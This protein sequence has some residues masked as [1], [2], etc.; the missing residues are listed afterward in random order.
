MKIMKRF[1]VIFFIFMMVLAPLLSPSYAQI[2]NQRKTA[3][4]S[5][6][7][8]LGPLD[9]QL[10]YSLDLDITMPKKIT[11]GT[12][13]EV[14]IFPSNGRLQTTFF[15]EGIS[16]GPF[17]NQINLGQEKDI[18]IEVPVLSVYAKPVILANPKVSG[19][20]NISP[21]SLPFT[22]MTPKSIQIH[23]SNEIGN[24]N[25]INL[26]IPIILFLEVGAS[27]DIP[28]ILT[29][30][31]PVETFELSKFSTISSSISLEKFVNTRLNL[32]VSDSSRSE[33]IKVNPSLSSDKGI[34][35][36]YPVKIY[37]DERFKQTVQS[38]RWSN[39]IWTG[40]GT[41]T[42]KAEFSQTSDKSNSAIIYRDSTD[43]ES[44]SLKQ[45]TS[46]QITPTKSGDLCGAGTVLKDGV[47]VVEEQQRGGGCL[48]ATA[49]YGS[50]LA[51]QVQQL[52]EIRDNTLLETESGSAFM[53]SFNQF[54]YSFSPGIADLERENPVFKEAVKIAI[55]PLITS[56]SIL[57][58]VDID[59]EAEVLGY[60]ISLIL[61]NVGMYFV[62]PA[63]VISKIRKIKKDHA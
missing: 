11:A 48:I 12:I 42:I 43:F 9:I 35:Y 15:L 37:I 30:S 44:Y 25:S 57:N 13:E 34:L 58:Y 22:S 63:I 16:Y 38:S 55:T 1:L 14:R 20:A 53:E 27:I 47:C 50:E 54:Y 61:L 26:Q 51:P 3:S 2:N 19:P 31:Y 5:E 49:T 36:D 60:G 39:E 7:I 8:S 40:Y 23:V 28:F 18:A 33:H 4:A 10:T 41:H 62:A 52:R 32:Q 59:S 21:Q 6:T 24:S 29:K 56:L 46:K 45:P 17:T